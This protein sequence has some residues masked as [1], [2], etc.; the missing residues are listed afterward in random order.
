MRNS[1]LAHEWFYNNDRDKCKSLN[2]MFYEG[3]AIFSYGKHFPIAQK[4]NIDGELVV[5]FTTRFRYSVTTARHISLV[6]DAIPGYVRVIEVS[7]PRPFEVNNKYDK[8]QHKENYR[9][10]RD[11]LE[12]LKRELSHKRVGYRPYFDLVDQ[13]KD[14]I[15]QLNLYTKLFKLGY[16]QI[17][18]FEVDED[19]LR[20]AR[21]KALATKRKK[22][23]R[24]LANLQK[25]L[26][27]W[28]GGGSLTWKLQSYRGIFLRVYDDMVETSHGAEI[29]IKSAK[30]FWKA[31][32]AGVSPE[33][34][35]GK[36]MGIY[37]IASVVL[38]RELVVGCHR[39]PWSEI[40][41]V[42][43]ELGL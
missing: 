6:R 34:L 18:E 32:E 19:A 3:M 20:E 13:I 33:K 7:N 16:R 1:E 26:K 35:V 4:Y 42:R 40:L 31:I 17:P 27:S 37:S 12:W 11:R 15:E 28:R 14:E 9:I 38:N 21:R 41:Y 10:K 8:K 30:K 23:K 39:I 5:L 29:D 25:D 24:E 22:E 36:R 2:S 43:D